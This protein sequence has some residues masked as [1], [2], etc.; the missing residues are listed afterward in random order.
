MRNDDLLTGVLVV[1][2]LM[3]VAVFVRRIWRDLVNARVG[4]ALGRKARGL[5]RTTG[6]LAVGAAHAAAHQAGRAAG[7]VENAA[8]IVGRSFKEGRSA[9]KRSDTAPDDV[10]R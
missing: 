8:G 2:V 5:G 9:T 3:L 7:K 10:P 4:Y 1:V 6:S